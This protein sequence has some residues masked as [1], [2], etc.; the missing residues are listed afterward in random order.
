VA[1]ERLLTRDGAVVPLGARAL[2]ILLALMARAGVVIE[3]RDLMAQVWPDATVDEG[4]L[5][6]HITNLRKVLGDGKDG[7]QYIATHAGHGYAFVAPL[8]HPADDDVAPASASATIP[9]AILPSRPTGMVGRSD[10]VAA[11]AMDLVDWRFVSLVGAGGVGKTTVAVALGHEL[12]AEFD[13]AVLFVDLGALSDPGL[14]A[15]T[16][17]AMLGLS[18]QSDNTMPGLIAYLRDKRVLLILDN[19]EHLVVAAAVLAENIF[20]AAPQVHILATSREALRVEGE[21]VVKV[22]PLLCPPNEPAHTVAAILAYPA[23]QLFI[24]RAAM[25]GGYPDLTAQDAMLVADICRKL[26][27]VPLAIEL[28]AGR[29]ESHGLQQTAALCGFR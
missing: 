15:S 18:V 24:E 19:C 13:S 11:L 10:S 6:F 7:A 16:V 9:R 8:A 28:A 17:A 1:S 20:W 12:M 29:V 5:R 26:D 4:S 27:G 25:S 2:D 21:R 14:V 23:A 3:K 22:E